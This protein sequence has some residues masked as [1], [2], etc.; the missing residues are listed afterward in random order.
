MA[1]LE[2]VKRYLLL[3]IKK[4]NDMYKSVSERVLILKDDVQK[5]LDEIEDK[6][7]ERLEKIKK[8]E[9]KEN[10]E[11]SSRPWGTR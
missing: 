7:K 4:L 10:L 1:I 2:T 9:I 5:A 8:G 3:V 6:T 11:T